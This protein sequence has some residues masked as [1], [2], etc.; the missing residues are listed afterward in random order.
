MIS[1]QVIFAIIVCHWLADFVF[2]TDK[3][4]KGKSEKWEDLLNHT[5][6]YSIIIGFSSCF[7]LSPYKYGVLEPS[8]FMIITFVCHTITDYFTSRFNSKLYAK[9]EK[10]RALEA[11][12]LTYPSDYYKKK[13]GLAIHNFFVAIGADQL[14][15]YA[16]LFLTY[17]FLIQ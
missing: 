4:A 3:M 10:Y 12:N 7:F 17:Y 5:F 13:E 8:L 9:V 2:Q 1:L 11:A 16:Q 14:L 15:H 6:V